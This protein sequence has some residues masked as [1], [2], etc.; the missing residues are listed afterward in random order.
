MPGAV[1]CTEDLYAT[2]RGGHR[3]WERKQGRRWLQLGK[4]DRERSLLP[5]WQG[6]LLGKREGEGKRA[7]ASKQ[8][9]CRD[10]R[11]VMLD[12]SGGR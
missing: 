1:K 4:G 10:T 2:G 9:R 7:Q 12:W 3:E 5:Q 6:G 8:A 11:K